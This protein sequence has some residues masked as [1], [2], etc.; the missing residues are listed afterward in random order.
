VIPGRG[1][2]ERGPLRGTGLLVYGSLMHPD[3]LTGELGDGVVA[4]PVR[5]RGYRRSFC[6]EPSWR[7]G[8]GHRRG[9]LTVQPSGDSWF[10]GILVRGVNP[11]RLRALD[12]R[13]RGYCRV[14]VDPRAV[15]P[16]G[17]APAQGGFDR[18]EIYRG[19]PEKRHPGLRPNPRYLQ[20]C[21]DAA[22]CWGRRF[23]EDF[24]A[25]TH[26]GST[27][28]REFEGQAFADPG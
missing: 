11:D 2:M 26:V 13:E 24:L 23:L 1:D 14:P 27:P 20:L 22:S 18:I 3:A 9:V 7:R 25:T 4:V 5:V 15:E 21:R 19:R 10:G 8:S 28:L 16:Y 6:Q 12:R 17:P